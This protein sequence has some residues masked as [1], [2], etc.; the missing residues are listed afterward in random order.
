MIC[1]EYN[2][3]FSKNEFYPLQKAYT[4]PHFLVLSVRFPG[5]TVAIYIGRGNQYQGVFLGE[6]L[7]PSYL[8]VQDRLLDYLRK[9]LVGARL[10][11]MEVDDK[12]M[13]SLF[14]FK[15]EHSDNAFLF[16]YKE[17]QLFFA[18]QSKEEVYLSWSGETL[19]SRN[20]LS[21]VDVFG[22][23]KITAAVNQKE[24]TIAEYLV[25]EAKKISGQRVQRKKEKFLVRK[26]H[27]ISE[28]LA[29][30]KN[31]NLL[32]DDL[33]EE[34]IDLN[35]DELKLHGQKI[36]LFGLASPWLKRDVIFKKI[37]KLKKAEEILS[38]RLEE[39]Q[40]EFEN[41][42]K[43]EFE[44]EVTKEKVI[45]PLW[46]THARQSKP[47]HSEHNIKNFKIK[48]LTGVIGL[49]ALSN[50]AI[51]SQA[52][53]EHYWFHIENYPG[54]HGIVKTD[55]FSKLSI[56]DLSA[57]ASM[58]RDYSRL[59]ILEIPMLYSQLK[60]VKGLK[61]TKGEVII[62]KPKHLRCLYSN[63]KEI[64]SIF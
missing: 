18:K 7:P 35:T 19:E 11:K 44:F 52:S 63:W 13:V 26:I 47:Q 33:V 16:G 37:K 8:R 6:K 12:S 22:P 34:R 57:I 10:G 9:Y 55:D 53:K 48:N 41:V 43:G 46:I 15:N 20:L 4:T 49:D 21:L 5:K 42:Q 17:R 51:R 38:T 40:V 64:I 56:E 31:W 24:W 39:S 14:H 54:A 29:T 58:L 1:E 25:E 62:K 32:Q 59:D 50:D 60:N 45:Q 27:N 28:D 30:V 2:S 23:D 3:L 61:G 36:K